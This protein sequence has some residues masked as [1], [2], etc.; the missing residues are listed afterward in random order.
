MVIAPASEA[1][2]QGSR[3]DEQAT[4]RLPHRQALLYSHRALWGQIHSLTHRSGADNGH[5]ASRNL[6][7]AFAALALGNWSEKRQLGQKACSAVM[8]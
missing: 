7:R 6:I 5:A 3:C 1:A 2:C 4:A 8:A